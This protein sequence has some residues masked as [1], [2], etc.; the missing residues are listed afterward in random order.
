MRVAII[1]GIRLYREG[2][3]DVLGRHDE[4]EVTGTAADGEVGVATV[5]ALRPDIALLDMAMLDSARTVRAIRET[6]PGVK[7]VAL[8]VPETEPH[9]LACAEAGIA[10]YVPREG[11]LDDLVATVRGV[12]KDEVTCPPR[13]V[14]GLFQR[15]ATLAAERRQE[16]SVARLT[17]REIDVIKLIDLGLTNREIAERLCIELPTVKN[18]VH[19][20]LEKLNLRRRAEAAAWAR[21][22]LRRHGE[23]VRA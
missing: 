23:G 8:A 19:S 14:A 18:H 2:L 15:V 16:P 13:I 3:A 11:S 1:A 4:I 22:G 5:R 21:R 7:V 6:A 17:S 12:V 20:I 10:A 9:V